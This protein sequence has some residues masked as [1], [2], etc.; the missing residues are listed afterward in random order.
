MPDS[1]P[2]PPLPRPKVSGTGVVGRKFPC[3]SCGAGV[4][5]VKGPD[6]YPREALAGE[7]F[8]DGCAAK[9]KGA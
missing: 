4:F 9:K 3:R 7:V 1:T 2:L 5:Q 6:G 8:C